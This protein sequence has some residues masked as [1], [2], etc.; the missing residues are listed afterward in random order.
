MRA[1]QTSGQLRLALQAAGYELYDV[2]LDAPHPF[3]LV[4]AACS[5]VGGG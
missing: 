4:D 3:A 2:P 1:S 5:V